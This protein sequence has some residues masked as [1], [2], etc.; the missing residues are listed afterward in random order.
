MAKK[1]YLPEGRQH[2]EKIRYYHEHGGAN[3]YSQA[4]YHYHKLGECYSKGSDPNKPGEGG[5]LH[6]MY[7]D[8]GKLMEVM[9]RREQGLPDTPVEAK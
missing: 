2:L 6:E 4:V 8:A 1:S 7:V 9:Q 3:G 5:I